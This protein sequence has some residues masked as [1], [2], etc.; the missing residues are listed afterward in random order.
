MPN[1]R[2]LL[3]HAF[4]HL[5]PLHMLKEYLILH[6]YE[7]IDVTIDHDFDIV[8]VAIDHPF[9]D[10]GTTAT[11][12]GRLLDG[13]ED[14]LILTLDGVDAE[15]TAKLQISADDSDYTDLADSEIVIAAGATAQGWQLPDYTIPD[16]S[17]IRV[18]CTAEDATEGLISHYTLLSTTVTSAG[19][20]VDNVDQT[21]TLTVTGHDADVT[22][23]LE[24]SDDGLTYA[25][26]PGS[27]ATISVEETTVS[28]Q[29]VNIQIGAYIR[30]RVSSDAT[31]G[32]VD[33]FAIPADGANLTTPGLHVNDTKAIV[34][35]RC[36]G[37]DAAITAHLEVSVDNAS[38]SFADLP[39]SE[40]TIAVGQAVT[41][42]HLQHYLL[43]R[44][45]HIRLVATSAS[46]EGIIH[47]LKLLTNE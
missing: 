1:S 13:A 42:W 18:V 25:E 38:D 37:H 2:Q 20:Q 39:E 32:N 34:A 36:I 5:T 23:V 21:A 10:D 3:F 12:T 19:V 30:V 14:E 16:D 29:F 7:D 35:L 9:A 6:G 4:N 47:K 41:Q 40:T 15:V 24:T 22:A 31:E 17:Y 27:E 46:T 8:T 33:N 43:P 45:C 26:L 28:W 11:A 44:G